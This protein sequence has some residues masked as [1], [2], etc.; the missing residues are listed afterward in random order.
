[1]K[2]KLKKSKIPNKLP[3]GMPKMVGYFDDK[4]QPTSK[5]NAYVV[6]LRYADGTV[7]FGVKGE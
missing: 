6:K 5:E 3:S 2:A 1:M 4:M 7:V